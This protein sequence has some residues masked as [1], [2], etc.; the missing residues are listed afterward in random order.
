MAAENYSINFFCICFFFKNSFILIKNS[1]NCT[2][3]IDNELVAISEAK[4]NSLKIQ[5]DKEHQLQNNNNN[6]NNNNVYNSQTNFVDVCISQAKELGNTIQHLE[7]KI[8]EQK[9]L[10]IDMESEMHRL[11]EENRALIHDQNECQNQLE[12][13]NNDNQNNQTN[14][15]KNNKIDS[16]TVNRLK[17]QLQYFQIEFEKKVNI[18]AEQTLQCNSVL[19]QIDTENIDNQGL[20]KEV[21]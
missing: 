1:G 2:E 13:E 14:N 11:R 20:F 16:D 3:F 8:H 18:T 15:N 19:N 4:N 7:S 10:L 12:S 6:N 17:K 9:Q 5:L 21:F